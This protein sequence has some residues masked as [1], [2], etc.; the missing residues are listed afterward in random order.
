MIERIRHFNRRHL[1]AAWLGAIL[2]LMMAACQPANGDLPANDDLAALLEALN[3]PAVEMTPLPTRPTYN[4]GELVTYTA[5]SGDTLPGL[6]GRFNTSVEEILEANAIIPANA[7]TL[8]PGLPMEIPIYYRPFWGSPY[9]IIPDSHFINGPAMVG[10]DTQAFLDRYP[11]W[12]R[13]YEEYAADKNRTAAGIIDYVATN[14]S[15]SPRVFITIL[16]YQARGLSSQISSPETRQYP[17]GHADL[18]YPGLYLQLVWAA[19]QLNHAYYGWRTGELIEFERSDGRIEQPDPWQNA[20]SMALQVYLD[21]T[22][23]SAEYQQAIGPNGFARLFETLFGDPWLQ[24][25]HIPGSLGQPEFWLPFEPNKSW[26]YTGGPHAGWGARESNPRAA[27]DFAPPSEQQGCVQSN[28]WAT[29]IAPGLV[30]RSEKGIVVLDLDGDGDERTG[31]V[32]FYLHLETRDRAVVGS[33]LGVGDPVGHPSCEGGVATGS[34]VH[35]GRKYNGEWIPASGALPFVMEGWVPGD[36]DN[37][38]EGSLTRFGHTI[39]ACE[40]SR[41]ENQLATTRISE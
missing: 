15:I 3:T 2:L 25:D 17:L 19:N 27:M 28:E 20:A 22:L 38:Y 32:I 13:D 18:S 31:W 9:Q 4:P 26:A 6:A 39:T 16:E 21:Q 35:L 8:P 37:P 24:E 12:L 29:A 34:H 10:F 36:G 40:C 14:Y 1:T 7:T 23:S 5:Q 30:V 33:Q 41:E 11:G